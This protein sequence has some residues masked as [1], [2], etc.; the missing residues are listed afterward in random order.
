M[1]STL[2]T[3]Y[4]YRRVTLTIGYHTQNVEMRSCVSIN[5]TSTPEETYFYSVCQETPS[6]SPT[7]YDVTLTKVKDT[8]KRRGLC[9][10]PEVINK[11][12]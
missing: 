6:F 3:V 11:I 2:Y 10:K 4:Y 5:G 9:R 12:L 8:Y 1:S 7:Y